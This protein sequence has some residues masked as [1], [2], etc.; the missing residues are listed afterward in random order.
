LILDD[1]EIGLALFL[2]RQLRRGLDLREFTAL[3]HLSGTAHGQLNPHSVE[4]RGRRLEVPNQ[5]SVL[6]GTPNARSTQRWIGSRLFGSGP[7]TKTYRV[8]F[9]PRLLQTSR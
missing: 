5:R 9:H 1:F 2:L 3:L 7:F 6:N 4:L 8:H